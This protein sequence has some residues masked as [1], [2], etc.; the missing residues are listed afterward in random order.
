MHPGNASEIM[1]TICK[2]RFSGSGWCQV[3]K[4]ELQENPQRILFGEDFN[5][6]WNIAQSDSR[7]TQI[8][9]MAARAEV[10]LL[11]MGTSLTLER[12]Y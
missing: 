4:E 2:Q 3:L 10:I 8:F 9:M 11:N 1:I 7:N 5:V 6:R 12:H